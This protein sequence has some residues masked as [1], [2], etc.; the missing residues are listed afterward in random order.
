MTVEKSP[1]TGVP[2]LVVSSTDDP[3]VVADAAR[4]DY[5]LHVTPLSWRMGRLSLAS[6]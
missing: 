6:A 4:E 2:P 5:T 3:R 1:D